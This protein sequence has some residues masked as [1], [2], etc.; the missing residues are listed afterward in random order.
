MSPA[1]RR[2]GFL[3]GTLLASAA[4]ALPPAVAL[5]PSPAHVAARVRELTG[6][7]GVHHVVEVDFGGNL[8]STLASVRLNGSERCRFRTTRPHTCKS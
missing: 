5:V 1:L 6:G 8:A 2:R 4:L 7:Q 3:Q